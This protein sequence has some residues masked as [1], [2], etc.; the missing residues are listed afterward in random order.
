MIFHY[1]WEPVLIQ[2]LCK[3][4]YSI[5]LFFKKKLCQREASP[6]TQYNTQKEQQYALKGGRGQTMLVFLMYNYSFPTKN[7]LIYHI[8][9]F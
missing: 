2:V 9:D 1:G 7:E 4:V 8:V 6:S 3:R 5:F